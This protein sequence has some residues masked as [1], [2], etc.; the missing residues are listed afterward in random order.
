[1]KRVC[2]CVCVC[3]CVYKD[4]N[5]QLC[6]GLCCKIYFLPQEILKETE[7]DQELPGD[8]GSVLS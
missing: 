1:M 4:T 7:G 2:V 5:I 8:S 6:D 3:V